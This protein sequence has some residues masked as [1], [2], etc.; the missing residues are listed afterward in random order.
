VKSE[1]YLKMILYSLAQIALEFA[2]EF[3][4]VGAANLRHY[5]FYQWLILWVGTS[6][7]VLFALVSYFDRSFS[8][9]R[10]A[11]NVAVKPEQP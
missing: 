2:K 9:Y 1:H 10:H 6:G 7:N 8:D 4:T 3:N 5:D 11:A